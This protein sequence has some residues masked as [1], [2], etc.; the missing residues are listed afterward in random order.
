MWETNSKSPKKIK[1]KLQK[2]NYCPTYR[3]YP[4]TAC[5]FAKKPAPGTTWQ[6]REL[7]AKKY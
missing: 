5:F 6:V 3:R 4:G 2:V 1:N 7:L